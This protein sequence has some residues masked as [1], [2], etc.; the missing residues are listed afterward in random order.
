M[1]VPP[2]QQARAVGVVRAA[3]ARTIGA[4]LV[5]DVVVGLLIAVVI[6]LAIVTVPNTVSVVAD[7]FPDGVSTLGMLR[8][9]G[10]ALPAVLLTVPLAA[11]AVRRFHAAPILVAG[12]TLMAAADAA[13]GFAGSP[14]VVGTLRVLH[15][16]GAGLLVPATLVA[17]WERPTAARRGLLSLWVGMLAVS[18]LTAQA[19]ALWP[20]D[21]ATSWQV[22]LQP[23]PLVSGVALGV[24]AIYL[25]LWLLAGDNRADARPPSAERSRLLLAGVLSAGIAALA[26][27]T[28]FDW[29]PGLV[30]AAACVSVIALFGLG[31]F[32]TYEGAGGRGLA[33]TMIVVGLVVLPTA[34]Q[35]TY[36]ELG[37][38]GGP[39]LSGL[40]LPFTVA[41][42][43]AVA[44][45]WAAGR[46]PESAVP[47]LTRGGLVA[48]VAGL[49]AVR[50]FVPSADGVIL[51]VPFA[52]IAGGAAV[53]LAAALRVTSIGASLFA[54]T[55][56]FPAVLTGFLLGTGM[57]IARLRAVQESGSPTAQDLVDGFVAALHGWAL[58]GGSAVVASLV[59]AT[60]LARRSAVRTE[61]AGSSAPAE[62]AEAAS[63]TDEYALPMVPAPSPSPEGLP[64]PRDEDGEQ[65][66]GR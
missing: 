61:S 45:A 39:G 36:V 37:G 41:A 66:A 21:Q 34:A 49:C 6:P 28:T 52:L 12:L 55:L 47:H 62:A 29:P 35:T 43:A 33:F 4:P 19:L 25:T 46:L 23:Y 2:I 30:L 13:G 14:L 40:W 3:I 38:L 56:C 20:L 63:D 44:A 53:A 8:A 32:G 50:F 31:S 7:L 22:A 58:V 5:L 1:A 26:L 27:G 60:A 15:G 10:L 42:A 16:V 24:A 51:V 54:L 11:L 18:L 17:A 57:Q 64:G 59:L 65:G 48:I 9:H